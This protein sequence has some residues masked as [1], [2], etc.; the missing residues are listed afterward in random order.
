MAAISELTQGIGALATDLSS[1]RP[2]SQ[3]PS[4]TI[5][6]S[7]YHSSTSLRVVSPTTS[8]T[9]NTPAGAISTAGDA[10]SSVSTTTNHKN[11]TS[12]PVPPPTLNTL[13]TSI[14]TTPTPIFTLMT[15]LL[16]ASS[17]GNTGT[18]F[19]TP[20]PDST[21]R[22]QSTKSVPTALIIGN[23]VLGAALLVLAAFVIFR[24]RSRRGSSLCERT[25]LRLPLYAHSTASGS[26]GD[27]ER[28]SPAY[29]GRGAQPSISS[30]AFVC[31]ESID[32]RDPEIGVREEN[33]ERIPSRPSESSNMGALT[34]S[35]SES[36]CFVAM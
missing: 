28:T 19:S 32:R 34:Q 15:T 18:K 14:P 2:T 11:S 16:T 25:R 3:P 4:G 8:T 33:V 31:P 10:P 5:T 29:G 36:G 26:A 23:T 7:K 13:N 21:P 1:H 30:S 20:S 22:N 24:C 9:H 12:S 6:K 17:T 27:P 35:H